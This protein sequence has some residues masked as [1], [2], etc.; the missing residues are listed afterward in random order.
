MVD[1]CIFLLLWLGGLGFVMRLSL[2]TVC[3]G[4]AWWAA[5]CCVGCCW[6]SLVVVVGSGVAGGVVGFGHIVGIVGTPTGRFGEPLRSP[7]VFPIHFWC[8]LWNWMGTWGRNDGLEDDRTID[9]KT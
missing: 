6:S 1:C 5:R 3:V 9:R 7:T 2:G 4:F 8:R